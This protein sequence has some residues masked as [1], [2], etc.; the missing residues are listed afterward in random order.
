MS[1]QTHWKKLTNP[2]YI[3]AYSLNEGEERTVEIIK[4]SREMI[5]GSDGKKEEC[6][7][8]FLKA[9][10]P[11]IL[12]VT[13]CKTITKILGTPYIENWAGKRIVI[14]VER[15]KAFGEY[16]DALRVKDKPAEL[17]QLLPNTKQ[18]T[19]AIAALKSGQWD[20][21]KIKT[22]FSL[23][24]ENEKLLITASNDTV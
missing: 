22:Q 9:E 16:V 6:T 17:P 3:G 7:V 19:G 4:V 11:F 8:A 10:K 2:D 21:N 14:Y 15:I 20:I 1:N 13:N 23:S 5:M 12:N 24:I 18:W